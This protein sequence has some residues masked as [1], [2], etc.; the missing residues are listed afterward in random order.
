MIKRGWINPEPLLDIVAL[1]QSIQKLRAGAAYRNA[2][3]LALV[4]EFVQTASNVRFGPE[5]YCGKRKAHVDVVGSFTAKVD[6]MCSDL[7]KI[8]GIALG[9]ARILR[10]DSRALSPRWVQP[11]SG[12]FDAVICSPPYPTEHDYTRNGR[13]ELALL[14]AVVDRDSLQGIKRQ[15]IRSHTKGIYI[16]DADSGVVSA[17]ERVES[18]A[19]RVDKKAES[20]KYGFARL[21]GRVVREYFGGMAKHFQSLLPHLRP[22]AKCAYIVGDQA[23]YFGIRVQTA[24]ILAEI[25]AA[26]GYK[27]LGIRRWRQ[28]WATSSRR[29]LNEN[30]LLLQVGQDGGR[31]DG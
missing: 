11:P 31:S 4:N 21:Y 29:Y 16:N 26:S 2:L 18:L 23:S 20:K 10:G 7:K 15:M 14:E 17:Y 28:R 25:A 22:E 27:I 24:E 30:I 9:T 19:A 1:K 5:L 13:L 12:G 6:S 3:L 8:E